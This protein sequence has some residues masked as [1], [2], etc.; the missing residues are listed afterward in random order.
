MLP[1]IAVDTNIWISTFL[2]PHSF[3]AT[4][5]KEWHAERF[6]VVISPPLVHELTNVLARPRL[7][8]KYKYTDAESSKF[9][10]SITMLAEWVEIPQ[11]LKVVRDPK[12]NHLIE[13]ALIGKA[14]YIVSRDEDIVR[15]IKLVQFLQDNQIQ[16]LTIQRFLNEI[17]NQD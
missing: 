2:T 10:Y 15:D 3:A 17:K 16:A 11:T 5:E 9:V 1:I 13:T 6:R 8:S 14:I 12:D 7:R 4:L